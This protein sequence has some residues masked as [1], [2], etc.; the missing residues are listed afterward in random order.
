[1]KQLARILSLL[2][3]AGVS[4]FFANCDGGGGEDKSEQ[5]VQFEKLKFTWTMQTVTLDNQTTG[6]AAEFQGSGLELTISGNFAENGE[7]NYDLAAD[8]Q[9]SA[10][11]WPD[12]GKWKFGSPVTSQI[13]RLDSERDPSFPDVPMTYV[14]SESDKKLTVTINDYNGSNWVVGRVA[15]VAGDWVFVFTRP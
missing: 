4:L 13:I 9:I 10:S 11:P 7:F 1:M 3:L 5:Q 6:A 14:L 8:N 2:T 12:T 15:S